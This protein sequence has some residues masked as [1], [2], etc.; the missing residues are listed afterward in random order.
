MSQQNTQTKLRP[1]KPMP[2]GAGMGGDKNANVM[3]W[4]KLKPAK[5][6]KSSK[7]K[8]KKAVAPSSYNAISSQI[9]KMTGK[10]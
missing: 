9:K 1:V 2:A 8:K 6:S 5:V 3:G 10:Q 4:E 7:T